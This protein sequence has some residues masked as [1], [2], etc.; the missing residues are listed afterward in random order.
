MLKDLIKLVKQRSSALFLCFA[1]LLGVLD[2]FLIYYLLWYLEDLAGV[3]PGSM[4]LIEGLV[5]AAQTLGGEVLF[6]PLS[7]KYV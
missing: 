7:G 4:K 5:V 1:A 6:F 2:G 3:D